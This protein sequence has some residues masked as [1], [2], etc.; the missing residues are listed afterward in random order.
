[1][2]YT[3]TEIEKVINYKTWSD[4]RKMDKL[5]FMDCSMY[6]NLGTDSTRKEREEVKKTS[7]KIYTAIKSI[8]FNMGVLF[9]QT[10]DQKNR[11]EPL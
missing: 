8:N 2:V 10:M 11:K 1:M 5:L 7:R 6:C 4:K 3:V 9:L